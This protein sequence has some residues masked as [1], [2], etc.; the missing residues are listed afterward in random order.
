Y[1]SGRT[2]IFGKGTLVLVSP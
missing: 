2:L 1:Q